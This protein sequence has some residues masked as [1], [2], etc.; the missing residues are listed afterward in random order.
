M[1]TSRRSHSHTHTHSHACFPFLSLISMSHYG[2]RACYSCALL[3]KKSFPFHLWLSH[4][5]RLFVCDLSSFLYFHPFNRYTMLPI[6]WFYSHKYSCIFFG[7]NTIK[8]LLSNQMFL[9]YF[10][11]FSYFCVCVCECEI[12]YFQSQW[13]SNGDREYVVIIEKESCFIE[14]FKE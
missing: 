11:L 2:R 1:K 3:W 12:E 7:C 8:E 10:P 13:H 5:L 6:G 14:L 9:S 4:R